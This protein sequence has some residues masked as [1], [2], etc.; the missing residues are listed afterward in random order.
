MPKQLKS[1]EI[2]CSSG[3][4]ITYDLWRLS[5]I[6]IPQCSSHGFPSNIIYI[7]GN[8]IFIVWMLLF[9]IDVNMNLSFYYVKSTVDIRLINKFE[10]WPH[11]VTFLTIMWNWGSLCFA[12][13][14]FILFWRNNQMVKFVKIWGRKLKFKLFHRSIILIIRFFVIS[15]YIV[16]QLAL[17]YCNSSQVA[18]V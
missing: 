10:V 15:C 11:P 17:L 14:I 5:L 18:T 9:Y 8:R 13:C 1:P 2:I 12:N 6:S 7:F 3:H 4:D 16:T